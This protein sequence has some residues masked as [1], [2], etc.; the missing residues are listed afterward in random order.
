MYC[1]KNE[2]LDISAQKVF[3]SLVQSCKEV[4]VPFWPGYRRCIETR[5]VG[6]EKKKK[7]LATILDLYTSLSLILRPHGLGMSLY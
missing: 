5:P 4:A 7:I 6:G 2:T 3:W 1:P